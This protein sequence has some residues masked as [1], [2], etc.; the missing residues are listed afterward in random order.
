VDLTLFTVDAPFKTIL[1]LSFLLRVLTLV[2]FL[3]RFREVRDVPRVGVVEML[4]HATRETTEAAVNLLAGRLVR[5]G[6]RSAG[7]RGRA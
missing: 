2:V 7:K 4:F 1:I 5:S 6:G 3:P